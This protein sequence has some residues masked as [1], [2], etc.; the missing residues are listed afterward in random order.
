MKITKWPHKM[1]T[2]FLC[3]APKTAFSFWNKLF[4]L[5]SFCIIL[6]L[7]PVMLSL[8][9]IM[10]WCW[11]RQAIVFI[12]SI[13]QG[14]FISWT[15]SEMK[16][17]GTCL[18]SKLQNASAVLN[19]K[20]AENKILSSL[21]S[22][23]SHWQNIK[24]S[25]KIFIVYK[26]VSLTKTMCIMILYSSCKADIEGDVMLQKPDYIN[27][28]NIWFQFSFH[29]KL[30]GSVNLFN[31]ILLV[32]LLGQTSYIFRY[33][34]TK[35]LPLHYEITTTKLKVSESYKRDWLLNFLNSKWPTI[36]SWEG[37]WWTVTW[38][39]PAIRHFGS[40]RWEL[41]TTT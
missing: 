27:D 41:H 8:C 3:W 25:F 13:S 38:P 14:K 20:Y 5:T 17:E 6:F 15:L 39:S 40:S 31:S 35:I 10:E 29:E 23:I 1:N 26:L 18:C 19:L 2:P 30:R 28:P 11:I 12:A 36:L 24:N 9:T 16:L 32:W 7:S 37:F 22:R 21:T 33:R 34:H 4:V